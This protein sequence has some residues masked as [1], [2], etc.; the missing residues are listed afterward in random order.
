MTGNFLAI[1]TNRWYSIEGVHETFHEQKQAMAYAK[2]SEEYSTSDVEECYVP[3][4]LMD[5]TSVISGVADTIGH[6]DY[7]PPDD[8]EA[9]DAIR[10]GIEVIREVC[11]E[12]E[13]ALDGEQERVEHPA[14]AHAK[15]EDRHRYPYES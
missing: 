7:R 8:E 9:Q 15:Q 4:G 12:L 5:Y 14:V 1:T 13:A 6:H 3:A 11:D 10:G 2:E